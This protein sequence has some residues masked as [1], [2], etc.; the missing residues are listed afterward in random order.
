MEQVINDIKEEV[1]EAKEKNGYY[2]M[3]VTNLDKS[4]RFKEKII[5][6]LL[7]F[8]T[9]ILILSFGIIGYMTYQMANGEY[10]AT[11][12]ETTNQEGLYNFYDSDGNMVS[13]DLSLDDMQEL[14]DLNRGNE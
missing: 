2:E 4:N 5:R 9:V 6:I 11:T 13:S 3:L 14:I 8:I 10:T 12:T 7:L 1:K